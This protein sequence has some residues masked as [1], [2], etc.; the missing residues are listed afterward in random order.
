MY[1]GIKKSFS[2]KTRNISLRII[3]NLGICFFVLMPKYQELFCLNLC[4]FQF[5][6]SFKS[7]NVKVN[8]K[9]NEL[10]VFLPS[11]LNFNK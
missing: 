5:L 2:F 10:F 8:R 1:K 9:T 3:K 6:Y 7:G 4:K 11:I